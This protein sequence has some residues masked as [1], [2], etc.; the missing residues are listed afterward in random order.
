M[1]TKIVVKFPLDR[2]AVFENFVWSCENKK[3]EKILNSVT[4]TDFSP[5]D[6]APLLTE[7]KRITELF[8]GEIVKVD[9]EP[10]SEP[11]RIY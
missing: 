4:R 3:F 9:G 6:P 8:R 2:E 10:E 5:S 11:G 7:A 1:I